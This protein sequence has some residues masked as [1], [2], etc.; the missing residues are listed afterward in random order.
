[1]KRGPFGRF[2]FQVERASRASELT[3]TQ[4]RALMAQQ[5]D[6]L[7]NLNERIEIEKSR[8]KMALKDKMAAKKRKKQQ[9]L[10]AKQQ[11]EV[12]KQQAIEAISSRS[13]TTI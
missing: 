10:E 11:F 8:Q 5:A 13:K 9:A 4:A 1:M 2:G 7:E 6:D 12:K 3:E